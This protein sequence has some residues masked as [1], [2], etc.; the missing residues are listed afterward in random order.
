MTR[1]ENNLCSIL[2]QARSQTRYLMTRLLKKLK[3]DHHAVI[4]VVCQTEED[5]TFWECEL[6]GVASEVIV[7]KLLLEPHLLTVTNTTEVVEQGRLWENRLGISVNE[8]VVG[9]RHLGRGFALGGSGHPRSRVS[10]KTTYEQ[11]LSA[12]V[13]RLDFWHSCIERYGTTLVL[14]GEKS[15]SRLASWK[16]IEYRTLAPARHESRYFWATNE[17]WENGELQRVY[18]NISPVNEEEKDAVDAPYASLSL[19]HI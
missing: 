11:M 5:K 13:Q 16:G 1:K 12:I 18:K 10:E 8:L 2:V 6:R 14:D 9:D 7:H 19:I 15:L 4:Y 17:Y 3:K